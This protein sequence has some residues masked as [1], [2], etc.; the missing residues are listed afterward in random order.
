MSNFIGP[1][2]GRVGFLLEDRSD[3]TTNLVADFL[4]A[5][6]KKR[7]RPWFIIWEVLMKASYL[8]YSTV[9]NANKGLWNEMNELFHLSPLN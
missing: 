7:S 6:T 4:V 2:E 8:V 5:V 9:L 1:S 3:V